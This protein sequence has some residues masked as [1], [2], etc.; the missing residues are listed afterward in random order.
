VFH[1]AR[2]SDPAPRVFPNAYLD[3]YV[4]QVVTTR[5]LRLVDLTS[6]GLQAIGVS[7]TALIEST[8]R[9]YPWTA[10]LAQRLLDNA[11]DAEGI[12]WTSRAHD[13]SLS[14]ALVGRPGSPAALQP[15]GELPLA[16]G[17]GAGLELL[18]ATAADARITV[19]LPDPGAR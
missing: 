3:R 6:V 13:R 17:V 16:L 19:V 18:R 15:G 4:S 10:A 1:D 5:D 8:P 2:P 7:R 14:V 9:R 12:L 11:P